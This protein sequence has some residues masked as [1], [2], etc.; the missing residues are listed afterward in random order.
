MPDTISAIVPTIGRVKSLAVLL[1]ALAAQTRRPD[2]IIVADGSSGAAVEAL[3]AD[4]RWVSRGLDV[5]YLRVMPPNAVRQRTA[6]IAAVHRLTDCCSLMT[7]SCRSRIVCGDDR[8]PRSSWRGCGRREF[9][10]S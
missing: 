6:A 1:D 7:M 2:E 3:A 9:F 5:R 8:L 10:Q 4:G